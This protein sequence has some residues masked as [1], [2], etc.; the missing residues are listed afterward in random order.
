MKM[1]LRNPHEWPEEIMIAGFYDQCVHEK[2]YNK[3]FNHKGVDGDAFIHITAQWQSCCKMKKTNPCV[4]NNN[5]LKN[6]KL[7]EWSN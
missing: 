5:K 4:Q 3:T 6:T 1:I 2:I 7:M